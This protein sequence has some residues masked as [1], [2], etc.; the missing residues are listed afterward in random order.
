LANWLSKA[1]QTSSAQAGP[2]A[3]TAAKAAASA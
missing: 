3:S 2:A 1:W